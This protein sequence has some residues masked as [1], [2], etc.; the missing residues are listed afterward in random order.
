M[1]FGICAISAIRDSDWSICGDSC[2]NVYPIHHCKWYEI[3]TGRIGKLAFS[4]H[5]GWIWL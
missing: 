2:N 3:Y 5:A 4:T 1:N